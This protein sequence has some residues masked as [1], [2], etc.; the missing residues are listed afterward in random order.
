MKK[1]KPIIIIICL[2]AVS[3]VYLP[4]D[5]KNQPP[6]DERTRYRLDV[7]YM[8]EYLEPHELYKPWRSLYFMFYSFVKPT[9]NYFLHFGTVYREG[10]NDYLGLGG[11]AKDWSKSFYTYTVVAHGTKS[12]YM[13]KFRFDHDFNFKL[14][15]KRNLVL[16]LGVTYID[17][18]VDHRD[19]VLN[20]G[21]TL[22]LPKWVME[23]RL[24]RNRSD[25]GGIVS[26]THLASINYGQEKK[27]W[28]SLSFSEGSQAYLATFVLT[29]EEIRQSAI[30]ISFKHRRWLKKDMGVFIDLN[31]VKLKNAWTKYGIFFGLFIEFK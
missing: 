19:F 14:L 24:F 29:P 3:Y 28:T 5:S 2:L 21:L 26:Y 17:Y 20:S 1:I 22:Y 18:H 27:S 25:P 16:T 4:A 13:P 9:F 6:T 7:Q 12:T 15:K 11:F 10:E 8:L 30:S 31:Y 23:Y